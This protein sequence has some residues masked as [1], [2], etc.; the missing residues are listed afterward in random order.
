MKWTKIAIH[1]SASSDVNIKEI[2]RRHLKRGFSDIGYHFVIRKNGDLE[3]GRPLTKMGAHVKSYNKG[4]IGICLTGN[5]ER[6]KPSLSQYFT[7]KTVLQ[8]LLAKFRI[9]PYDI[10]LHKDF[11]PTACPGKF[12]RFPWPS[13]FSAQ[14]ELNRG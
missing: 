1:H 3:L 11:A 4:N 13:P 9:N 7:L 6:Y 10:F 2:R 8:V 14:H 5:F 12:F